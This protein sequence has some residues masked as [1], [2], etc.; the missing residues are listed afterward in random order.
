MTYTKKNILSAFEATGISPLNERRVLPPEEKLHRTAA[1]TTTAIKKQEFLVP[2]TPKHGRSILIHGRKTLAALPKSTPKSR[3]H[4]AL[5]EKLFNAAAQAKA[6]N[7]ILTIENQNLR[8]KATSAADKEKTKSRK[9]MSKA[10]VI[11]V[12]DVLRIREEQQKKEEINAQKKAKTAERRAAKTAK[13]IAPA[14]T[15][16][17]KRNTKKSPTLEHSSDILA[18]ENLNIASEQDSDWVESGDDTPYQAGNS[19]VITHTGQRITRSRYR[20]ASLHA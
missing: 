5:V 3:Y 15:P 7:V 19:S 11:S 4:H 17:P 13:L 14:S 2:K 18:L 16:K 10:R 9:E 20:N 8:S 6:D 12:Q 1:T